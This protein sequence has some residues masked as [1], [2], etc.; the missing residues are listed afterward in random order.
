MPTGR[1]KGSQ[2]LSAN[3]RI[4]TSQRTINTKNQE[5]GFDSARGM[6][7]FLGNSLIQQAV[8][9]NMHAYLPH[10]KQ[11][12]F[13]ESIATGKVFLGGNRSG[14]TVA[15]IVEDLWWVT[16]RHPYRVIPGDTQIRGRVLGDGFENGTIN[17]VLIPT[18]K[19]WIL[20]SDLINGSWEDSWSRQDRALTLNNGSF[21]EFK[22]YD[23]DIQKH[24]GTSRHFIHFDEEPPQNIYI[25]NLIRTVDTAGSWWMTMTPLNGMN[26]VYDELYIPAKEHRLKGIV[27][28]EVSMLDNPHL[29]G[30]VVDQIMQNIDTAEREQRLYG[31]FS[32]KGGLIFP[33]FGDSHLLSESPFNYGGIYNSPNPSW[34]IYTS[35]DFGINNP[36]AILWHAVSSSNHIVTFA[37]HFAADMIIRDHSRVVHEIEARLKLEERIYLRAGD[38]AGKQRS[39]ITGTSIIQEYGESNIY[40]STD[41]IPRTVSIGINKMRTY[42]K[43]GPNV[44]SP[45]GK[46]TSPGRP[47]WQIVESECPNLVREMK[48]LHWKTYSSSKA[49]DV[50]NRQEE[51]HKKDDHAFDSAR[52]FFTLLPDLAPEEVW[53]QEPVVAKA[54]SYIDTLIEMEK[55]KAEGW[56]PTGSQGFG[57]DRFDPMSRVRLEGNHWV[58]GTAGFAPEEYTF[59]EYENLEEGTG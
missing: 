49:Q 44:L 48:R 14:K 57:M 41:Y 15:G 35:F 5:L 22:S 51:V 12:L 30:T 45:E 46:P 7:E 38:P 31:K 42:L 6:F 34:R 10:P 33:E 8:E 11:L 36:T 43:F 47:H 20:P 4:G 27:V 54:R 55:I 19:R 24:A 25:E 59:S 32:E 28:F 29:S 26:W 53:H 17:E 2:P 39:G 23:Q 37:E 13:H 16:R 21:I 18:F 58:R 9:P 52:Y 3:K 50:N 56:L 1:P 40:I